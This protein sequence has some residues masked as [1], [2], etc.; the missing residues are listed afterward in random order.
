LPEETVRAIETHRVALKGPVTTPIGKGF[1]S[2]SG[3]AEE[4]TS[5]DGV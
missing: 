1:T 3:A 5:E 4:R 2:V